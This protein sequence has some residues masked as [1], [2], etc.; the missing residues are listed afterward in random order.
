MLDELERI[1]NLD[2]S[3]GF[4]VGSRKSIQ[5]RNQ[6]QSTVGLTADCD[7][8]QQKNHSS[9]KFAAD[10]DNKLDQHQPIVTFAADLD[11]EQYQNQ[12]LNQNHPITNPTNEQAP[13]LLNISPPSSASPSPCSPSFPPLDNELSVK[14]DDGLSSITIH[15][16]SPPASPNNYAHSL[17]P[18]LENDANFVHSPPNYSLMSNPPHSISTSIPPPDSSLLSAN[19]T[20]IAAQSGTPMNT[21]ISD[22]SLMSKSPESGKKFY[23]YIL[24]SLILQQ[25]KLQQLQ[26]L[27]ILSSDHGHHA[28]KLVVMPTTGPLITTTMQ[29]KK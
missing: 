21:T 4:V 14:E 16:E 28:E 22:P 27:L 20:S 8:S 19:S 7:S 13:F 3:E 11:T 5:G 2:Y 26:L 29:T 17:K 24:I 15:S 6:H 18:L 23:V 25:H 1:Q 9:V 12:K 10:L